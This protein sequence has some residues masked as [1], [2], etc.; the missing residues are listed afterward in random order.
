MLED[1]NREAL[2]DKNREVL[3]DKNTEVLGDKS[4]AVLGDK[5]QHFKRFSYP[6]LHEPSRT[7]TSW[8]YQ[9]GSSPA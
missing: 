5:N 1:N 6:E 8:R 2:W 9:A 3:G 4:R 7:S